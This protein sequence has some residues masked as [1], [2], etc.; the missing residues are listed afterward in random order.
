MHTDWQKELDVDITT[1]AKASRIIK[2]T[3]D[4]YVYIIWKMYDT[5]PIPFYVG[6][7]H[8]Q[9]LIK[10]EMNSEAANNVYKTRV[11]EKHKKLGLQ[12]GY[13]IINFFSDEE[14]AL[15]AEAELISLIGRADLKQGPL[16]NKTDGG[17]GSLG[18]LAPK[19]GD[20]H[21]ARPVIA[22]GIRYSCLKDASIALE[23][24]PGAISGRIKNGWIDYYYEDEGQRP[25]EK[26]ILGRY[27]KP[28]VVQ[29]REFLS[30][31][32]ASRELNIDVRMIC[33]RIRYGWGG[34]YY[35][36]D[37][38]LERRTIWSNRKDK[39]AVIINEKK[40]STISEAVTEIGESTAM[41]SKRCLSSNYPNY[42]RLD[43][44]IIEKLNPPR[45]PEGVYAQSKY[46]ESIAKA[47]NFFNL[48]TGGITHRCKSANYPDWFFSDTEKQ[49][50]ESFE[51]EF[52]SIPICVVIDGSSYESQSSAAKAHDIDINTL[53]KRCRSLSFPAWQCDGIKKVKPRDGKPGLICIEIEGVKYRSISQASREI[54]LPRALIKRRVEADEWVNYTTA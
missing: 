29:G 20:S 25:Q 13:S 53:K 54:G 26:N 46:F 51:P 5:L 32:D 43:G 27:R 31:S 52:S 1:L 37:G 50:D 3:A 2:K 16:T 17:D 30:V 19:G 45:N 48:T 35:V 39:V 47:S 40:F 34:Y 11:I 28:V 38:Q 36:E 41:I 33:K 12:C 22:D 9:R 44:K 49:K 14:L 21:S 8:H 10:H 7:G 15:L 23:V 18:H 4:Y 24:E 42:R 6:K